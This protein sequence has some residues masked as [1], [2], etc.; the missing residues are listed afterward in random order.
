MPV[1]RKLFALLVTALL[2]GCAGVPRTDA[3]RI[4]GPS[5]LESVSIKV[6]GME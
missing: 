2:A 4:T 3:S 1:S 6:K 5:G